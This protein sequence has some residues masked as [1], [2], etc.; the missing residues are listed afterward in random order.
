MKKIDSGN[1][2]KL[3]IGIIIILLSILIFCI[4][5]FT[6]VM[7]T[8]A[9]STINPYAETEEFIENYE[10]IS[11]EDIE[12]QI[13]DE[14]NTI[15]EENKEENKANQK[16]TNNSANSSKK[17]NTNKYYIKINY[18]SNSITVYTKDDNDEYTVPVK[19]MICST[20]RA[21]P[22]SG[23][24]KTKAKWRWIKLFG[25]VYGQY[26]TQIVGNILFHSVPYL[27]KS[28]DSL[29]YWEY[30][31]LGTACSAG[32]I[33][34]TVRD[35]KWI[36]DNIPIG[37]EIE[38][39]ASSDP[40]PLGKPTSQKISGNEECRNWDPTDPD[41]NNPWNFM[42]AIDNNDIVDDNIIIDESNDFSDEENESDSMNQE[43]NNNDN[44]ESDNSNI[45]NEENDNTE[46][47]NESSNENNESSNQNGDCNEENNP[48]QKDE[49]DNANDN[50]NKQDDLELSNENENNN[51]ED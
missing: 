40:G 33:R 28:P 23:V 43:P 48:E 1:I 47:E 14:D 46:E 16:N 7:Q 39:H 37:T 9:I 51:N 21:T 26:S 18:Q 42:N 2:L 25:N 3:K 32:C 12:E 45:G 20:G 13:E 41:V 27:S 6:N 4:V 5:K 49:N 34:L 15:K 38:F 11:I 17:V 36:Y 50:Q 35:A 30:D 29:E 10:E 24:Y 8:K 31:K 22:R 44:I 19:A